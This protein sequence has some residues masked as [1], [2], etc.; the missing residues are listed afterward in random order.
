MAANE[1]CVSLQVDEAA[2]RIC[3]TVTGGSVTGEL[4]DR[5]ELVLAA[6]RCVILV[7]ERHSM[8]A[9]NRLTLTVTLDDYTG[10]TRVHSVGGGGGQGLFRFDWGASASFAALPYDALSP[11]LVSDPPSGR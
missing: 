1:F 11:F 10:T 7:F 2:R 3:K 6:G 5:H 4:L 8:R 9:G